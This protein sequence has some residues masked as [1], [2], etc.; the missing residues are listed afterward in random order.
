MYNPNLQTDIREFRCDVCSW[1]EARDLVDYPD[2]P[3]TNDPVVQTMGC[4][5]PQRFLVGIE[6]EL[7]YEC[8]G[9]TWYHEDGTEL[10]YPDVGYP[11][12]LGYDDMLLSSL[13]VGN[14]R[15]GEHVWIP[16]FPA[17]VLTARVA[18][19]DSFWVV[20]ASTDGSGNRERWTISTSG[21]VTVDGVYPPLPP[22]IQEQFRMAL[23]GQGNY[24]H[25]G[26]DTELTFVDV[27]VRRE[28]GGSSEVVYT[29]EG[30]PMVRIHSSYL[31]TGP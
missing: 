8:L 18:S 30:D 7:I 10:A 11:L 31:V 25:N 28:L 24:I 12:S 4:D 2:S 26:L 27:I 5:N 29:E 3:E 22:G 15:T 14:I 21:T 16:E 13:G 20:V 9:S 6:D 17:Q 23:D 1:T 19:D